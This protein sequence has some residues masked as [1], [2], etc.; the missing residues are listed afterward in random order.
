M[1]S[2]AV[3]A[4]PCV[5]VVVAARIEKSGD[6]KTPPVA[7][8]R[9]QQRPLE[10]T[11]SLAGLGGCFG[12]HDADSLQNDVTP[13]QALLPDSSGIPRGVFEVAPTGRPRFPWSQNTPRYDKR[14]GKNSTFAVIGQVHGVL[15]VRLARAAD[16][17]HAARA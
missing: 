14:L 3:S 9:P 17:V 13:A 15:L 1:A 8:A 12:I 11:P 4:G 6:A 5:P 10:P 16:L 7:D 2:G